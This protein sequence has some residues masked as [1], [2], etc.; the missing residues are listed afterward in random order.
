MMMARD[1]TPLDAPLIGAA[2]IC[3]VAL[4][5]ALASLAGLFDNG[6]ALNID[7]RLSAPVA[8]HWFGT[9]A[10]GRDVLAMVGAGARISIG[11]ALG[12]VGA[13]LAVG[14]PLGLAAAAIGGAVD[15]L[16]SRFNDLVFAVPS[17]LL[18]LLLAAALGPGPLDA[19]VALGIFNVPVFARVTR[20]GAGVLLT[21]D[22]VLAARLAGKGRLRIA[23]EHVLPNLSGTL[24][25]QATIQLALA[26]AAEAGLSYIGLGAQPPAASW[27]RMLSEAQTLAA[28]APWLVYSPG[29]ALCLTVLAFGVLGERLRARFDPRSRG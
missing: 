18:A 1:R 7:A 15:E 13:G 21:R 20:A 2:L 8:A 3:V 5:A 24:I 26:I 23:V 16:L 28:I 9:D 29:A 17:L 27:G 4:L 10:L 19:V 6:L 14:V 25:V 12:A 22:F 11:V